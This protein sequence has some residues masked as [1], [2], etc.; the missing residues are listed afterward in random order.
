M[1]R[2]IEQNTEQFPQFLEGV[3]ALGKRTFNKWCTHCH[4][5]GAMEHAG[6]IALRLKYQG[7][8]PE[9]LEHRVDLHPA[10]TKVFVRN[11]VKSMPAF[12]RT[13]IS[14]AELEA[15][16]NYLARNLENP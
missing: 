6:T 4:A 7:E 2:Y 13:E 9:A 11:G 10:V 15:L 14:E 5:P 1:Q 8:K 3:Y 16:A 12:R